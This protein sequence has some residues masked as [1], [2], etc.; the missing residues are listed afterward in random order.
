MNTK[1]NTNIQQLLKNYLPD[2]LLALVDDYT[3]PHRENFAVVL[4]HF[5]QFGDIDDEDE[6][7]D[8]YYEWYF[9]SQ[10]ESQIIYCVTCQQGHSRVLRFI[11]IL[12]IK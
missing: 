8:R 4:K 6:L 10:V 9:C 3:N 12:I 11:L 1:M 7:T 5:D 2:V